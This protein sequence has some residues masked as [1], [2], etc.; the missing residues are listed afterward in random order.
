MKEA[1]L[2]QKIK[3]NGWYDPL[4]KK[5]LDYVSKSKRYIH[6]LEAMAECGPGMKFRGYKDG[7]S[8][9]DIE[10]CHFLE[11]EDPDFEKESFK[12]HAM[13]V[14]IGCDIEADLEDAV[15]VLE[16]A[17]L[18]RDGAFPLHAVVVANSPDFRMSGA[19][20]SYLGYRPNTRLAA[21]NTHMH[22]YSTKSTWL[23]IES[24]NEPQRSAHIRVPVLLAFELT[25]AIS[26]VAQETE[27]QLFTDA[28]FFGM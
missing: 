24:Y 16:Y 4:L 2:I 9:F 17:E 11:A 3:D 10:I 26:E 6:V 5:T 8:V 15:S 21:E 13:R 27:E 20:S 1:E 12:D 28:E 23:S 7:D 14:Y 19:L 18:L 22:V 25:R